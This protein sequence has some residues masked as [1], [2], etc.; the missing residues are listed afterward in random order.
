M[1]EETRAE[2]A[3]L[4]SEIASLRMEMAEA[5]REMAGGEGADVG[6]P[7]VPIGGGDALPG[8]FEP[9]Y[10]D[11]V[12]A[13]YDNCVFCA[14]RQFVDC[15]TMSPTTAI[16]AQSTGYVVLKIT[17]PT[18]PNTSFSA[19]DASVDFAT[20]GMPQAN[21]NDAETVIPIYHITNGVVDIDLRAVPTGVLAR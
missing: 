3:A 13:S 7:L 21:Q 9:V 18:T 6:L 5:G 20:A 15:G 17:H 12:V 8:A 10:A 2:L 14:E 16:T 4:R 1:D 11:G 19:N